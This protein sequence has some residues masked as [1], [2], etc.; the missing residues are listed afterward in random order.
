[1]A[2]PKRGARLHGVKVSARGGDRN[3]AA[4]ALG[5]PSRIKPNAGAPVRITR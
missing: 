4:P 1:M 2:D 5:T 3:A